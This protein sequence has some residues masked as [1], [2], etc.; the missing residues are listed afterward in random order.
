MSCS[1][2][3]IAAYLAEFE[4]RREWNSAFPWCLVH[5]GTGERLETLRTLPNGG[6]YLGCGFKLKRDAQA[7]LD[8]LCEE[9]APDA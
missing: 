3:D 1:R 5:R 9:A 4:P 7:A 2:S 6:T 8:R